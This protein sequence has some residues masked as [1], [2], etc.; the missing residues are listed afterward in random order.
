MP[1]GEFLKGKYWKREEF[2]E[3]VKKSARREAGK[4]PPKPQEQINLYLQRLYKGLRGKELPE[5]KIRGG[6][7]EG[8][9]RFIRRLYKG[10]TGKELREELIRKSLPERFRRFIIYKIKKEYFFN[11]HEL[12]DNDLNEI[13]KYAYISILS[14][15]KKIHKE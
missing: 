7:L 8:F 4:I 6:F 10:L 11:L 9:R 2:R 12:I 15:S 1:N 14:Q 3:A 13:F 5:E